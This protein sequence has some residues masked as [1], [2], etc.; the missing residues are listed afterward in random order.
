MHAA[1]SIQL[2]SYHTD[3]KRCLQTVV[4]DELKLR[5]RAVSLQ[6]W[7]FGEERSSRHS[8]WHRV[9]TCHCSHVP[10][11]M[12][13]GLFPSSKLTESFSTRM[14]YHARPRA[15]AAHVRNPLIAMPDTLT[16]S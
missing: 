9:P 6:L 4:V 10:L 14:Q 13:P 12:I 2:G 5:R 8:R 7:D 1:L 3:V 15:R 11:R 16:C